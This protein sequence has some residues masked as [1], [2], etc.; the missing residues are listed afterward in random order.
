MDQNTGKILAELEKDGLTEDTI[1]FFYS[2]HGSGM[3]RHKRLL[4]DSGMRVP[5]MVRVPKKWQ[6]LIPGSE[7]RSSKN[8]K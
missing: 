6:H 7:N 5:L 4:T 2:D 3:P 8:N 1:V